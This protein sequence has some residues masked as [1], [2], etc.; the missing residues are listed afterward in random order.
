MDP[1]ASPD[2]SEVSTAA[3]DLPPV[4]RAVAMFTRPAQ[5]WTGLERRAQWWIPALF[6]MHGCTGLR[7]RT[8]AI[9]RKLLF[10][11]EHLRN[12]GYVSLLVVSFTPRGIDE[13]C[14]GRHMLS[15]VRDRAEPVP[16]RRTQQTCDAPDRL[17]AD[18]TSECHSAPSPSQWHSSSATI[19]SGRMP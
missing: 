18:E 19:R 8:G 6:M 5:A 14:T 2:P 11:A 3:P 13:V 17:A 12:L 7:T 10:W 4:S 16:H 9:Q 15:P 1:H